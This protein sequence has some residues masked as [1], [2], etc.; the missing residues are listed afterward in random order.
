DGL[1]REAARQLVGA[2]HDVVLHGRD[3]ARAQQV[4]A[5]V[6]G[7]AAEVAASSAVRVLLADSQGLVRA[8]FRLLLEATE[9]ISVVAEAASGAEAV[10]MAHRLRPDVALIEATLPGI[11]SVQTT[12]QISSQSR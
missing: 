1:G 8:G 11:D 5:G 3:E 9:L 4:L 12:R 6:P 7:A 10:A 2:G